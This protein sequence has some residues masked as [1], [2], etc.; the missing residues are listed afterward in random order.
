MPAFRGKLSGQIIRVNS[1]KCPHR[2]SENL[3]YRVSENGPFLDKLMPDLYTDS[4]IKG[5][6]FFRAG[7]EARS[8]RG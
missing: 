3:Q 4:K 1:E 2:V 6:Y 8:G 5:D 7:R